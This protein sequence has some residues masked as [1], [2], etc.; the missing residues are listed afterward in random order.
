MATPIAVYASHQFG[1]VP[2]SNPFH[3]DIDWL[4]DAGV[5]KGC[6]GSNYCPKENVTR[7]Q[8]AAFM[9]RLSGNDP[10]VAPS[11]NANQLGGFTVQQL[12]PRAVHAATFDAQEGSPYKLATAQKLVA[13]MQGTI[14]ITGSVEG[15]NS[16][17][18]AT[19]S[20]S[21]SINDVVVP[22]T[23][24]STHLGGPDIVTLRDICSTNGAKNVS[25]GVYNVQPEVSGPGGPGG[26]FVLN[27]ASVWAVWVPFDGAGNTPFVP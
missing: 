14:I 6:G 18:P 25:A 17:A 27:E 4:A 8:M 19:L 2:N 22:G 3:A 24:K 11:V 10:N 26:A 23:T 9:R 15:Y 13:P 21:L 12:A 1:D 7:E 5:T 20:C 16:G